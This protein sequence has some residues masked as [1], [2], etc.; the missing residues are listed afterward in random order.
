[1]KKITIISTMVIVAIATIGFFSVKNTVKANPSSVQIYTN[2][3]T[4]N[5]VST[6][7][8]IYTTSS[9]ATSTVEFD[10]QNGSFLQIYAS[11]FSSSTPSTLIFKVQFSSDNIDWYTHENIAAGGGALS[12]GANGD[13]FTWVA[14]TTTAGQTVTKT[15]PA[16]T[17]YAAKYGRVQFS[18]TGGA[19]NVLIQAAQKK[20]F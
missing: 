1:M 12:N 9:T 20:E 6:T 17:N 8:A 16:I 13:V 18:L 3:S 11:S 4:T 15:V 10:P 2:G 14:A 7:T 5:S 19:S